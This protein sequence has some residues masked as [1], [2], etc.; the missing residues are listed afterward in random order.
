MEN[1][2][3]Y[4]LQSEHT[5]DLQTEKL[6]IIQWLAGVNEHRIIKQFMLLKQTNQ[7][8]ISLQLS[9]DEKK[10][11]DAGIASIESGRSMT[12]DEVKEITRK[13]FS[14]LFR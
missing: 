7:E 5:S 1:Y 12:H 9:T 2:Y 4:L 14:G 10:A 11:I 6:D 13:K 3:L 8:S